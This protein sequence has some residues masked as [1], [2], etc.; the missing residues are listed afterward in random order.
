MIELNQD[1]KVNWFYIFNNH[2][3]LLKLSTKQP[4]HWPWWNT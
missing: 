2:P 4:K 3:E 1:W